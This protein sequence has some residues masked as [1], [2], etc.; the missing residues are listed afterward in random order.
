[1][2]ASNSYTN[3]LKFAALAVSDALHSMEAHGFELS[4]RLDEAWLLLTS[5]IEAERHDGPS[6]PSMRE[7]ELR[8]L[9]VKCQDEMY[10]ALASSRPTG[11]MG[12]LIQEIDKLL[13]GHD[14]PTATVERSTE[15]A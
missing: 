14:G 9:L 8:E 13:D 7:V 2:S 1:M 11:S 10:D 12:T 5:A 3:D 6:V 15:G 4:D